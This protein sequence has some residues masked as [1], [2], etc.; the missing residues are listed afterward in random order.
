MKETQRKYKGSTEE[1]LMRY[2]GNMKEVQRRNKGSTKQI[3][4]KYKGN[5]KGL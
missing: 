2:A 3:Q 1:I 5:M 4:R